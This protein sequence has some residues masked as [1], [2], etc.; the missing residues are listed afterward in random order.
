MNAPTQEPPNP[1]TQAEGEA[2]LVCHA[3]PRRE[4]K[5]ATLME[6][7]GMVHYL[8]LVPSVRHYGKRTKRFTKPLFAGYVF[9]RVPFERKMRIFQFDFLARVLSVDDEPR[10]LQQLNDVQRVVAAGLELVRHPQLFRGTRVRIAGGPLY[11]VEGVVDNPEK[12]QGIIVSID[13][14]QQGVLVRVPIE[15]LEPLP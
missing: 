14:L 13:V 15:L 9:A 1:F 11:G 6:A 4:K 8:P 2:W 5:F 10:F 3:R 7:E 12:P